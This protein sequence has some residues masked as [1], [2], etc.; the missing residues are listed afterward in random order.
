MP[1]LAKSDGEEAISKIRLAAFNMFDP[2]ARVS[3]YGRV[4]SPGNGAKR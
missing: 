1:G 2:L 4:V 3:E